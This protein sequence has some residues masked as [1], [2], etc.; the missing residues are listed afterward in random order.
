LHE[1]VRA[2]RAI[3]VL[4]DWAQDRD[5]TLIV[6]TA[7]HET[8]GFGFSYS[9]YHVPEPREVDGSGFDGVQYAPNFNFGPVEVL[10]RLWAQN[11]S[12]AAILSRLDAAEEQTPEVLRAIVEEVTGFTLT[13]EQAVAIL[14]REPN[15]YRIE[16]HSYLDAEDWPEV[17]DFEAFYPFSE[18]T[19][20]SLLARALGEQQSVTWSTGT[21]TS[22]PVELLALGPDSV[23]ALFNGLMHHAEVGQTLLRIVGGQP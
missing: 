4:L 23:T 12:Y 16:G 20:A 18:D 1:M 3:Q 15:H 8:G 22:T 21:H 14:A 13:E 19:R 6:V 9:R 10:D 17:H 11:D 5:D 2:D 7:D